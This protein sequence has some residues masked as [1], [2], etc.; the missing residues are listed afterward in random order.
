MER[1]GKELEDKRQKFLRGGG[2]GPGYL[3]LDRS[4]KTT[5][6]FSDSEFNR[7]TVETTLRT[8]RVHHDFPL[9]ITERLRM[10]DNDE[11]L[12]YGFHISGLGNEHGFALQ[13]KAKGSQLS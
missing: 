6:S 1:F 3:A 2:T 11:T 12:E 10:K 13:F 4:N 7:E 9:E 5:G 8:F